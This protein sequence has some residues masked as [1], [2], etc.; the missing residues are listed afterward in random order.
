MRVLVVILNY[1]TAELSVRCLASLQPQLLP[2]V[3][4]VVADND[5]QDGSAQRIAQVIAERGWS[6]WAELMALPRNGGYAYGNNAPVRAALASAAPPDYVHLLNPDTELRPGA[7]SALLDFMEAHPE[8]GFAGSRLEDPD[9]TPQ[10]SSFRFPT[11]VSELEAG[12]RFGPL[13]RLLAAHKIAPGIPEESCAVDW[14]AGASVLIRRAV[15]ER[16]GL[17]DEAYF[18][19]YEE[20]DF[21][22]AAARAGFS[23]WY[24]PE[25]R[26]M[27]LVGA[28]T[29][30]SD[31]R[32]HRKRRPA[33]WF[34]SRRRYFLKNHGLSQALAADLALAG[35]L[36]LHRA[37][38]ALGG[39]ED[40]DPPRML[41]DLLRHSAIL[42]RS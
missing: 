20:V 7:L 25:S 23:C 29:E 1:R 8:V 35:G 38:C 9:G 32:R 39:K 19:Y 37:R 41:G 36:V 12:A 31:H 10:C 4:A 16:V 42:H 14:V 33:Y 30:V 22:L 34:E 17:M 6:S 40:S 11:A 26:V 18:L 28:S 2:G 21:M 13:S 3:R 27:H 24:V 15:F 5:S